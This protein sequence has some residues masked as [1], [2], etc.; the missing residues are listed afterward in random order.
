M[1]MMMCDYKGGIWLVL[2]YF[3]LSCD[4]SI[5]RKGAGFSCINGKKRVCVVLIYEYRSWAKQWRMIFISVVTVLIYV[6][7][8][9]NKSTRVRTWYLM[10][11]PDDTLVFSPLDDVWVSVNT[12]SVYNKLL[13]KCWY[14]YRMG[15]LFNVTREEDVLGVIFFFLHISRRAAFKSWTRFES[16]DETKNSSS[17]QTAES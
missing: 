6:K 12:Y 4:W 17:C 5:K 2:K 1:K 16:I 3:L 15:K 9:W 14:V 7:S 13:E 8:L 11:T 10:V